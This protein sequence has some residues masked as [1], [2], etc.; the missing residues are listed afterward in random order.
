[1]G[2]CEYPATAKL[3]RLLDESGV[4][5]MDVKNMLEQ[6]RTCF[7][8]KDAGPYWYADELHGS[9]ILFVFCETWLVESILVDL[10]M[11]VY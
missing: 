8:L 1:M 7:K 4:F 11:K 3:R 2:E 10:G 6:R 9:G 5:W